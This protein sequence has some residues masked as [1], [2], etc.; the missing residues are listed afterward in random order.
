[1][2]WWKFTVLGII[3]VVF[4]WGFYIV[5]TEKNSLHNEV[6]LLR[7]EVDALSEENHS[8]ELD[9]SY[10]S[11]PENI[12]KELKSKFNYREDGEH[13]IILVPRDTT[14]S[15]TLENELE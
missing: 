15:N 9:I 10:F 11:S 4:A 8:L 13:L 14:N 12:L 5:F 1:M 3:V 7:D 6:L 2:R